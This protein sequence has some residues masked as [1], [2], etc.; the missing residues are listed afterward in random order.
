MKY[1]YKSPQVSL[2]STNEDCYYFINGYGEATSNPPLMNLVEY[3]VAEIMDGVESNSLSSKYYRLGGSE[4]HGKEI[5]PDDEEQLYDYFENIVTTKYKNDSYELIH[6]ERNIECGASGVTEVVLLSI[7][8]GAVGGV[9]SSIIS[10]LID[11]YAQ[12]DTALSADEIHM[13]MHDLIKEKYGAIGKIVCTSSKKDERDR[14]YI[15]EDEMNSKFY[16]NFTEE[17]GIQSVKV[18][19]NKQ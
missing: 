16:I 17:N 13:L 6:E 15:L 3:V 4:E 11:I 1:Y 5:S 2:I 8:S 18:R 19:K 9:A 14:K 10:K 7:L 12:N